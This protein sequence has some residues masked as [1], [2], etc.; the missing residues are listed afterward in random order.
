MFIVP[1]IVVDPVTVDVT[2]P[3][4][5]VPVPLIERFSAMVKVPVF[6]VVVAL[7]TKLPK[8]MLVV[9]VIVADAVRVVVEFDKSKVPRVFVIF[10]PNR[11]VA[12]PVEVRSEPAP[13]FV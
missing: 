3:K 9:G 6:T 13:F 11:I 8:V 7:M 1:F 5:S 12:V 2:P 4:L 10:P